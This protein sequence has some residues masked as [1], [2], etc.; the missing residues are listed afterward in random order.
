M[1]T[2]GG[3]TL[4]GDS[5]AAAHRP[6]AGPG[7]VLFYP[8]NDGSDDAAR[9]QALLTALSVAAVTGVAA[10]LMPCTAA[11][12]TASFNFETAC[13]VPSKAV[14]L[15]TPHTRIVSVLTPTGS[16]T[17]C[18]FIAAPAASAKSGTL[19]ATPTVGAWTLSYTVAAGGAPVAGEILKLSK[20]NSAQTFVIKT[21][22]GGGPYTLTLDR[23]IKAAF[24]IG[25]PMTIQTSRPTGIRIIGN[26]MQLSGTGDRFV[27]F[28]GAYDCHV[29]GLRVDAVDGNMSD[30]GMSFDIGSLDCSFEDCHVDAV[31]SAA[32]YYAIALEGSERCAIRNCVVNRAKEYGQVV[33][34]GIDCSIVGGRADAGAATDF[35][36]GAFVLGTGASLGC[37]DCV[38]DDCHSNGGAGGCV[39]GLSQRSK[40]LNSSFNYAA[41]TGISC[42]GG[43]VSGASFGYVSAKGCAIGFN[44]GS[45]NTGTV[46]VGLDVSNATSQFLTTA[47]D[48]DI[49]GLIAKKT[50]NTMSPCIGVT[51]AVKVRIRDLQFSSTV[52]DN[53]LGLTAAARVEI[54]GAMLALANNS[55]GFY[56]TAGS[57]KFV[58]RNVVMSGTTGCTAANL[59]NTTLEHHN[60]DFDSPA[61]LFT[62]G[63]GG[64][65]RASLEGDT[66]V[67]VTAADVTLTHTQALASSL[68]T[69]GAL[70]ANHNVILPLFT[71]AAWDVFCNNTGG[72]T[73]TFKTAA[74]TGVVVAQTKY[75]R[76]MCDG[77]NI[78][79]VSPDT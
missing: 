21:V 59:T 56:G 20:T 30:M 23:Q 47:S 42:T 71:G 19:T 54:D 66:S 62:L 18:V 58:A 38:L 15:G 13:A 52:A 50:A 8:A 77:T 46:V 11:G 67:A 2:V 32:N 41:A 17:A 55:I 74:G 63:A 5:G 3:R 31:G 73:T 61:T 7:T 49:V 40:V 44:G 33:I 51:A 69:T 9:L 37:I 45:G 14:I 1:S 12:V 25:D 34:D 70:G 29:S 60:C 39:I 76:L 65:V 43:A 79:R 64:K 6:G 35:A 16:Q 26:G 75:A 4:S 57:G 48:L 68:T 36:S 72:F 27:E 10:M 53:V 78:V 24:T 28:S 22:A